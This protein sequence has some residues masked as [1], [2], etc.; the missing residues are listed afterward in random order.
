VAAAAPAAVSNVYAHIVAQLDATLARHSPAGLTGVNAKKAADMQ[1]RLA[2]LREQLAAGELPKE[3]ADEVAKFL[4][5]V[6]GGDLEG[7]GA[8]HLQMTQTHYKALGS[9][10]LVGL[11]RLTEKQ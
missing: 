8:V 3:A 11:K 1:K 6:D 2:V 10:T 4:T 5:A 7:A 9:S